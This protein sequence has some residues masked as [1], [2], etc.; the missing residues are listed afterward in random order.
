MREDQ[1]ELF[2][3]MQEKDVYARHTDPDTS[4]DAAEAMSKKRATVLENKV[5]KALRASTVG[6]TNHEIVTATGLDWNTCTP[7]VRPLVR[8]GWVVDTGLRKLGPAGR[9]CIIWKAV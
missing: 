4:F 9:N 1:Y 3:E 2:E 7:R 5:L 8:K 6:L